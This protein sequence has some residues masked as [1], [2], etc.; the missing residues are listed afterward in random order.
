MAARMISNPVGLGTRLRPVW[1]AN[2]PVPGGH[3]RGTAVTV[4]CLWLH[5]RFG[6]AV[7]AHHGGL[8]SGGVRPT[9]L[10]GFSDRESRAC[11]HSILQHIFPG[12]HQ[13]WV[14]PNI[15]IYFV[16]FQD[17]IVSVYCRL[18]GSPPKDGDARLAHIAAKGCCDG[19]GTAAWT[20]NPQGV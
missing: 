15:F 1:P 10:S 3:H 11:C 7:V 19:R 9:T 18:K 6:W 17:K 8:G 4:G 5:C 12:M 16:N 14:Q 2:G 13:F 20:V